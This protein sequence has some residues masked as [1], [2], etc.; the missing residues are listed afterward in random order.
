MTSSAEPKEEK[1]ARPTAP[2]RLFDS[3]GISIERLPL[4]RVIFD[5]LATHCAENARQLS[6][7]PAYFTVSS[8]KTERIGAVLEAA[9]GKA[10]VAMLHAQA[11]DARIMIGLDNKLVFGLVEALFGGDGSEPPYTENRAL[12]NIEMRVAQKTLDI[13]ARSLQT[14]LSVVQ[15]MHFKFERLETRMD[16]AVIAPRNSFA[17]LAK[18][19]LRILGRS[20][21]VFVVLPQAAINPI[22]QSLSVDHGTDVAAADPRWSKQIET[23]VSKADVV[24][25]AILEEEGFTLA[26]IADLQVGKILHLKSTP[27]SRVKLECNSEPLF[28][29]QLGQAEGK[30]TLKVDDVYDDEPDF[31]DGLVGQ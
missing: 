30:Y 4:L 25:Q 11:W 3:A 5:R 7:A 24:V 15:E 14:A 1:S 29:C 19:N 20:G 2:E 13:I 27:K 21:E 17:V 8:V 28:W 12:T 22:R 6:T 18:L 10:I 31:L 26:D 23:E 9:E 16:F